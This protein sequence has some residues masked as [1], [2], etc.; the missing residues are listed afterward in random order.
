MIAVLLAALSGLSY[1]GSDFL[2]AVSSKRLAA[3]LV[4][5]G[6]QVSSLVALGVVLLVAPEHPPRLTDLAWA[7]LAGVSA[8]LGITLLYEALAR[9]PIST[10]ASLTGLVGA[11]VPVL[12]GLV[13]GDRPGAIAL[14]G[15]GLSIPAVVLTSASSTDAPRFETPRERVARAAHAGRTR[16]LA[17]AAGLGFGMFFVALSRLS[18]DAGLSPLL[19]ARAGAIGLLVLL[20]SRRGEWQ[21]P[22]G[23]ALPAVAGAGVLDCAA[24]VFYLE[25]L[26]EGLFTWVVALA[27][28]YPVATVLLARAFLREHITRVQASGLALAAA[29]LVLVAVGR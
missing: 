15:I 21:R 2:G 17:V 9:G 11:T 18:D 16:Q 6:V 28:L 12:A 22:A 27:S 1:G 20:V 5:L 25:A 14:A 3:A 13:L 19:G 24:N 26:D 29:A 10:A 23:A 7:G 4:A 8:G